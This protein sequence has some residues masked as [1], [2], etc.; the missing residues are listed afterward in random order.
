MKSQNSFVAILCL[1]ITLFISACGGK[2]DADITKEVQTRIKN[3]AVTV[4]SVK[5]GV[6]TLAGTVTTQVEK[7]QAVAAAKG[8]GV[9]SVTDNIQIKPLMMPT[10]TMPSASNPTITNPV[11]TMSP[12]TRPGTSTAPAA[13]SARR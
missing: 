3:P 9:K 2:S 11:T 1:S 5:D 8:E 12:G 6:V 10:P 7:E 4:S 13:N